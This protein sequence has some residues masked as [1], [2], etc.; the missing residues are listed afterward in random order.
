M[1]GRWPPLGTGCM[2]LK[3][4]IRDLVQDGLPGKETIAYLSQSHQA[5]RG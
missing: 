1:S 2:R 4:E 3:F 5:K